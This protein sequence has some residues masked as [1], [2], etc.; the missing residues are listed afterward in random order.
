MTFRVLQISDTHLSR[1]RPFFDVNFDAVVRHVETTAPDLVINTGDLALDAPG[2]PD[3]LRHARERHAR[4]AAPLR[5][6]PGN[7]DIGDNPYPGR[8]PK[9]PVTAATLAVWRD[10]FGPDWWTMDVPGWRFVAIDAQLL[11]TGLPDEAEQWDFLGDALAGTD[12]R[13]VALWTHKPLFVGTPDATPEPDFRYLP[14]AERR[15]LSAMFEGVDL[16]LV[17]CGHAHQHVHARHGAAA[18]VW[19]PA[20]AFVLPDRIQSRVGEKLCGVV[21]YVFGTDD[22][23]VRVVAPPGI[24]DL[25]ITDH[26]G[27]YG[28]IAPI[29]PV[30]APAPAG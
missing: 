11:G 7:H 13:K 24:R 25:D 10:L 21:E 26:P 16:R 9:Q 19:A 5:T 27:A 3:D 28:P 17:A 6:I 2:R 1:E 12:G 15:R 20:T 14:V 23:T 30:P 18:H 8:T 29:D 22:V 4:L